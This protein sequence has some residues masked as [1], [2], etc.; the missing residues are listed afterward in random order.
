MKNID[1]NLYPQYNFRF[2]GVKNTFDNYTLGKDEKGNLVAIG[3]KDNLICNDQLI[4]DRVKFSIAWAK[5][6]QNAHSRTTTSTEFNEYDYEYAF[7]QG[8]RETY[9]TMMNCINKQL[10]TTGNIDLFEI[11]NDV[12]NVP[13]K[14][15]EAYVTN[16]F[17]KKIYIEAL[18][19]WS[20]HA[21]PNALPSTQPL[22]TLE[23]LKSLENDNTNK[24]Y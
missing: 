14:Y 7:N 18:D 16:L 15:S 23:E 22:M 17:S 1:I 12:K 11:I 2:D 24:M 13:Y 10:L 6:T 9:A 4:I 20:R 8:A 19:K 5:A 3:K 21:I